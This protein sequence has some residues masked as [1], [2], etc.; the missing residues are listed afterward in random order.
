MPSST[1]NED[2]KK[3]LSKEQYR[4]LREKGTEAPFSGPLDQNFEN[5]MYKCAACGH[6]LFSSDTKFDAGCGWPSFYDAPEGNVTFKEDNSFGMKRT[7]VAC[8]NCGSHLGHIFD[9]GPN[10]T[11]KRYCINSVSLNFQGKDGKM[12]S[13]AKDAQ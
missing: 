3:K 2:F 9:D 10:P 13:G 7:E 12:K 1:T 8:A 11:G 6:D 4:V 5:G